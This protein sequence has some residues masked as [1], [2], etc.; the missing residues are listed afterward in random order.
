MSDNTDLISFSNP[1]VVETVLGVQFDPLKDWSIPY[2]G[3]FWEQ[4][5]ERYPVS[6]VQPAI[7][8]SNN[9]IELEFPGGGFPVRCWFMDSSNA[10]LIQVQQDRFLYNWRK[11]EEN[12]PYPRYENSRSGYE[13]AWT[14]FCQFLETHGLSL[15]NVV[16]CEVTYI[17]HFNQG[18]GWAELSDIPDVFNYW[19][20]AFP[21]TTF[22]KPESVSVSAT[23]PLSDNQGFLLTQMQPVIDTENNRSIQ[24][25]LTSISDPKS[26][27]LEDIL[28]CFD[29]CHQSITKAFIELTSAKMHEIWGRKN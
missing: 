18:K 4:I 27:K 14:D 2:Y 17:N 22:L 26:S 20:G 16:Q 29:F 23:Y 28:S 15:P 9:V 3:L 21:D 19:S 24:F 10:Q 1:P 12:S 13:K 25:R 7:G 5:R 6:Q 8:A 11:V